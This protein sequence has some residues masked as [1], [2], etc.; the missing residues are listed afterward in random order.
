VIAAMPWAGVARVLDVGTGT[1]ALLPDLRAAAPAARIVG[2]DRAAGM[3]RRVPPAEAQRIVM[4]AMQLALAGASVDAVLM[5][6]VLF[7]L[8]DAPAALAE[9]RRVLRPGGS[10]AVTTWVD[11]PV[12]RAGE[13]WDAELAAHGAWDP[14]PQ[15]RRDDAMNS[16]VKLA[17]LLAAAGFEPRRAWAEPIAH[18]WARERFFGLRTSFGT[19]RRKLD[20]LAPDARAA[21]LDA[22]RARLAALPDDAFLYRATA[23]CAVAARA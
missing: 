15:T 12:P 20:T 19:A 21:A 16:P 9:V 17:R 2:V 10:L 18:Q 7:H 6:F 13:V 4:D 1:G 3:L 5:A 8:P 23:A 22:I 14:S 11:D